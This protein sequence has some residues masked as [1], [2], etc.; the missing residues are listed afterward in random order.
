MNRAELEELKKVDVRTVDI[1]DLEDIE[2]IEI[3]SSLSAR[4]R[5]MDFAEKIKNPFCFLCNGMV[6]KI[7]YSEAKESLEHKLVQLCISMEGE[8][9]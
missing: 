3:D 1:S 9:C 7:S 5:W 2:N 6:V 4:E 8:F